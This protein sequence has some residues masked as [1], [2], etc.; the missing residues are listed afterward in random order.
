[1]LQKKKRQKIWKKQRDR[2]NP[3]YH[4]LVISSSPPVASM[5]TNPNVLGKSLSY[6]NYTLPTSQIYVYIINTL[7]NIRHNNHGNLNYSK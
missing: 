3:N 4:E 2:Y 7:A 6:N 5:L 1:M